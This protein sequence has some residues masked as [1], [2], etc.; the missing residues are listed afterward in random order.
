[1]NSS[2]DH[3]TDMTQKSPTHVLKFL[4]PLTP[5]VEKTILF[6]GSS[7]FIIHEI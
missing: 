6:M 3:T 5:S 1:M 2:T 4:I 7:K